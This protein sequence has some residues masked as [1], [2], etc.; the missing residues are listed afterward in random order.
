MKTKIC[1]K[2]K[3]VKRINQ[4]VIDKRCKSRIS[5]WCKQCKLVYDTLWAKQNNEKSIRVSR[6]SNL[7][8]NYGISLFDYNRMFEKQKGLCAICGQKKFLDVDH[9]HS[10]G[11]FRGLLCGNCN[12]GLG[13][14]QESLPILLSACDYLF[15]HLDTNENKDCQEISSGSELSGGK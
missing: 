3:L 14:F 8:T 6:E 2:C 15:E 11:K 9:D 4:F 7:K 12:R 1:T 10:T 5:S 13:V